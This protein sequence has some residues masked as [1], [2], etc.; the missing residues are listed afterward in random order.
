MTDAADLLTSDRLELYELQLRYGRAVDTYDTELIRSVFTE[1]AVVR[2]DPPGGLG[3]PMRG[4][5]EFHA[6]W[7]AI[8]EPM[9]CL[10]QFTNF[11]F[12]LDGDR[13]SYSCLLYAQHWPRGADFSG[14]VPL[15]TVGGRYTTRARRESGRWRICDHQ[16][17]AAWMSG[18]PTLIWPRG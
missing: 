6:F 16:M 3:A 14:E 15:R 17:Q 7:V 10:H 18:D 2:Y 11:T 5:E 1:D 8:Q 12:E 13:A 4:W 9:E